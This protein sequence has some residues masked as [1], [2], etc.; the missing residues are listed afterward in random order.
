VEVFPTANLKA[1]GSW[2]IDDIDFNQLG[3]GWWGNL[4]GWQAGTIWTN[5]AGVHDVD[6]IL[7]YT[8]LEPYVYSNRVAGNAYTHSN[9]SLGHHL[10]PNA[11]EWAL[12]L[13]LRPSSQVRLGLG[14]QRQRHGMNVVEGDSVIRNVGGSV[15]QGHRPED[16]PTAVFLD[17]IRE[18]GDIFRARVDYEPITNIFLLGAVAVK[19]TNLAGTR[20]RDLLARL[21]LRL[22][23]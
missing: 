2:L 19:Y 13:R 12:E 7:E 17:G 6:A 20:S 22:E 9:V 15:F 16:S 18:T 14:Y 11:D 4:F 8:R 3:T 5:V 21:Q 23:Y 1:Y 10:P